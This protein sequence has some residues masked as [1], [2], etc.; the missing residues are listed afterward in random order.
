MLVGVRMGYRLE[1]RHLAM[2]RVVAVALY[3]VAIVQVRLIPCVLLATLHIAA[4]KPFVM[5]I[6]K[7][8]KINRFSRIS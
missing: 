7:P 4:A 1:I 3:V 6:A 5:M 2:V 8:F